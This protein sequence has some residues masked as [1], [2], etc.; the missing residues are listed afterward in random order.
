MLLAWGAV[1]WLIDIDR[2]GHRGRHGRG[3]ARS[4]RF[5]TTPT[6]LLT[7][8]LTVL[9]AGPATAVTA[10]DT[11]P[12]SLVSISFSPASVTVSGINTVPVTI[13]VRLTD[14]TGVVEAAHGDGE[15]TPSIQVEGIDVPH[16]NGVGIAF[17]LPPLELTSGTA[18]DGI[19][20][21][22]VNIP[23]TYNRVHHVTSVEAD[24]AAGNQLTVDPRTQG[25]D[26][27]LTVVGHNQPRV[28]MGFSPN[29][30][31]GNGPASIAIKGRAVFSDTGRPIPG[32][33]LAVAENL[34]DG[35]G[36][37]VGTGVVTN[38]MGYY[39][40]SRPYEIR[41]S[42]YLSMYRAETLALC[43]INRP[44][45][46]FAVSAS[47][48]RTPI[49]LGESVAV[50]GHV[51]PL[52]PRNPPD[53]RRDLR[54]YLQRLVAGTWRT[55]NVATVRSSG[56]YT[57]IATP[58]TRGNHRYRTYKVGYTDNWHHYSGAVSRTVLVG[59]R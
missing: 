55:V 51:L 8:A 1:M 34:V 52:L 25:I 17:G 54:I 45:V 22:V 11:I 12:P 57:L 14:D 42:Y 7:L 39:S 31:M 48:A 41:A 19:W 53:P 38:S 2:G 35:G 43:R 44:D 21:T 5:A 36:C 3:R 29:P 56:R 32:L 4:R 15:Q 24:D 9:V 37:D 20:S 33:R 58:P 46:A 27:I 40:V 13:R 6:A 59:V 30:V 28:S 16:Y 50:T 23:S 26:P 18:K 10:A 49:R 47:V